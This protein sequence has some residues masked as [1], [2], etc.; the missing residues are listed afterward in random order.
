MTDQSV[1][2]QV[3]KSR[4]QIRNQITDLIKNYLELENVDLTKSSFLSFMVDTLSVLTSNL[5]FYQIS[6]YREFFLTKAQLPESIFN[7]AAFLGYSP[8]DAT[9]ATVNVLFTIPF[10]FQDPVTSFTIPEGFELSGEGGMNFKTYYSTAI[11]VTSNSSASITVTE[12]NRIYRLPVTIESDQFLFV[13]PFRNF[14]TQP[15][16]FQISEDLQ[17]YQFVSLEVPFSGQLSELTVQVRPP[18]STGLD[19]YT[20]VASLF[21]MDNNTKGYVNRKTDTGVELQFG[22]GLIGY[23]PEAGATVFVNL[24][25]T[26]GADGNVI[27]G[28]IN[29]GDRIYNTNLAGIAQVVQY[30]VTNASAAFGGADE[31]SIE[32]TRRGAIANIS[33]LERI[34]TENDFVHANTIIDNSPIGQNS[35]PVLKRS[36]LKVNEV[37][38]F[39]TLYF[40]NDLVPTRN[41]FETFSQL[42]I[43]RQTVIDVNGTDFYTIFDIEIDPLNTVANYTYILFEIEQIP[44]LVT[45]YGSTYDLFA[46]NLIVTRNGNQAEY[47]LTYQ[48]TESN[49]NLATCEMEISENGATYT[50]TNDGTAF[51]FTFPDYTVIPKG[52]LTYFFTIGHPTPGVGLLGQYSAK[53]VFRLALD[54]FTMSN[55]VEDGTSYIVYDIPVIK[56]EYYDGI[57]QRE[58]ETQVLQQLLTTME[59]KDYRMLTDFINFKFANTTGLL[60]NMK[61]N[62][63]TLPRILDILS[64]PPTSGNQGDRYI[65]LNGTGSWLGQDNNIASLSDT[66]SMIWAFTEPTTEDIAYVINKGENYLFSELGWLVPEY[67]IPLKIELDV[68]KTSTYSGSIG[69]L[70]QEIR[71]T[72]VTAFEGRF[73]INVDLY[74]SEIID[75]VH[76]VDGVEHCR[77][78]KPESSIFFN[79]D[80]ND[81]TQEQL[82]QY[83]PEYIYFTSDDITIRIF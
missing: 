74:R 5:L 31:E 45:S 55:V 32:E 56:K 4:D 81:F 50:M 6:T 1:S 25:L 22:N 9:P 20:E 70:T 48:S 27:A 79:F 39:S 33:A 11:T 30:E 44:T 58:F 8:T 34:L 7:L 52:E 80:I 67:N 82:L 61:L 43:P 60:Q 36:D 78:I 46:D 51:V 64:I 63:V 2:S 66:T 54:D 38:L 14:S 10:G 72:L 53:F 47:R 41:T 42:E 13:L 37:C 69:D 49:S 59:F 76:N 75:V 21:L 40:V 29:S 18:G 16:E 24:T 83:G 23:Q 28:S 65:V 19:I 73:G 3:Y 71:N 68:F 15:Q 57:N 17:T 35:L 62:E 26:N 12:G 77:L